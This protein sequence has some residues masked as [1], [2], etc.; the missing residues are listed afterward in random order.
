MNISHSRVAC[1]LSCPYKH[2]LAYEVGVAANKPVRPLRFG[3]DFHK[4]LELRNNPE[5]LAKAQKG[6]EDKFYEMPA[7]WQQELGENYVQD[8]NE[9]FTDYCTLYKDTLQPTKTE[10]EFNITIGVVNGEPVIFK[11]VI[12]E[13]YKRKHKGGS[14][15]IKLGEHKTFNRKPD[16]NVLVMNTQKNLY[17]KAVQILSGMLPETVIWDYIHSTPAVEPIWLVK[18]NRLSTAKSNNITPFSYIRACER[19][20]IMD[21]AVLAKA[22]QFECN[23]PN[24]FFRVEMDIIPSMV[25]QVWQGFTYTAQQIVEQGDKNKTRSMGSN[26]AFCDFRDICYTQLT[27]GNLE[28]LIQT[29]YVVSKRTDVTVESRKVKEPVFDQFAVNKEENNGLS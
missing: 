28:N 6:I 21:D 11:G 22:K 1:Y 26:C 3:T 14:K 27:E 2:Y 23:I 10:Q 9:I 24:F 15:Y 20:N 4:L 13:L 5:E 29:K 7:A 17:A 12:D 19:H 8:L 16:H 25:E 18:S